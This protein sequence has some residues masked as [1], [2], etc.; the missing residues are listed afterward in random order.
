[1]ET[2][3][4]ILEKAAMALADIAGQ[5]GILQ[6]AQA[7]RFIRLLVQESKVMGLATV[8][9]LRAPKQLVNK[10]RFTSR[11]LR[12]GQEGTALADGD[13]SKPTMTFVEHDAQLVKAEIR[14][15]DEV[16]EDN[17]EGDQLR[18]TIMSTLAER[19]AT[20]MDE[21]LVQ[22]DVTSLDPFLA[23][24]DGLLAGA[25]TN[26][27]NAADVTLHKGILRDM[28]KTMPSEWLRNKGAMRFLT[29][30]D[31][32]LDYRDSLSDR[33]TGLGDM[34]LAAVGSETAVVGYSGTPVLDI[35]LFP[36]NIG[37]SSHCTDIILTDPK[38]IDVGIWRKLKIETDKDISAGV[39]VVVCT[40]RFDMVYQEELAVV[41]AINVKV[42]E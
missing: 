18:Q 21:L 34:A 40:M 1:M 2:N 23:L 39:L 5:N 19:I 13:R 8:T 10:T 12:P 20:D 36:E 31:A 24:F 29:S 26:V 30:V 6:T 35:P 3:R 38:N 22:G 32:E 42:S 28:L 16:L 17:I 7:Q 11:V 27:V 15:T 41:K 9:P 14:I 4:T 37:T 33:M 25:T